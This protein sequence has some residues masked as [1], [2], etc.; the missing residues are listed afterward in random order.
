MGSETPPSLLPSPTPTSSQY[1]RGHISPPRLFH[2]FEG[3]TKED[4][5]MTLETLRMDM[6]LMMGLKMGHFS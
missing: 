1:C 5:I 4:G 6:G 3:T 2:C